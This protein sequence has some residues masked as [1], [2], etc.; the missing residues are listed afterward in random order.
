MQNGN[1][2]DDGKSKSRAAEGAAS[3]LVDAVEPLKEPRQVFFGNADAVVGHADKDVFPARADA[4]VD[5]AA[6]GH[7]L[8]C[9]LERVEEDLFLPFSFVPGCS[10]LFIP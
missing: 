9:V 7:R 8:E 2:L 10:V 3:S 1:V 4:H 6:V 5:L